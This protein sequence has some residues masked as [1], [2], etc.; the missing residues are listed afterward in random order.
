MLIYIFLHALHFSYYCF[1][2]YR[3][4]RP[5][6]KDIL[7]FLSILDT[8][9]GDTLYL[10]EASCLVYP[11][12]TIVAINSNSYSSLRDFFLPTLPFFL[13]LA[14]FLLISLNFT[15]IIILSLF[16][17]SIYKPLNLVS[18]SIFHTVLIKMYFHQKRT[19]LEQ[20]E[21][22]NTL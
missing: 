10:F 6:F 7:C 13:A 2:A 14:V 8:V 12:F 15:T 5:G 4:L 22:L 3:Y 1:I 16:L 18:Q 17:S 21:A 11:F 19:N 9:A 20:F